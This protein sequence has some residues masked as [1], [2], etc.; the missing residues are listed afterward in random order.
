MP[1]L[2]E[3]LCPICVSEKA[4]G[5][6]AWPLASRWSFGCCPPLGSQPVVECALAGLDVD[7]WLSLCLALCWPLLLLPPCWAPWFSLML[8]TSRYLAVNASGL[9]PWWFLPHR[10]PCPAPG[11]PACTPLQSTLASGKTGAKKDAGERECSTNDTSPLLVVWCDLFRWVWCCPKGNRR[12]AFSFLSNCLAFFLPLGLQFR[13]GPSGHIWFNSHFSSVNFLSSGHVHGGGQVL[14]PSSSLAWTFSSHILLLGH[15][16]SWLGPKGGK[17]NLPHSGG[18][19]DGVG[20]IDSWYVGGRLQN[21]EPLIFPQTWPSRPFLNKK[22]GK[23]AL[24]LK[25]YQ[26]PLCSIKDLLLFSSWL[27]FM[28]RR[29]DGMWFKGED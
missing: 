28:G 17:G 12:F 2:S 15:Q 7:L 23:S 16:P 19:S 21:F 29:L 3:F 1:S 9:Q 13:E 6:L 27:S 18:N 25:A 22:S 26:W 4:R 10:T 5:S 24:C 11:Q 20:N 8:W 14:P